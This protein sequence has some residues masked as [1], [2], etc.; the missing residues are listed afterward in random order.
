MVLVFAILVSY[1]NAFGVSSPYW[2]ERP[3]TM[4]IGETKTVDLNLQ[5]VVGDEA[6]TVNIELKDGEEVATLSE[7]TYTVAAGTSDTMV[8]LVITIP[9]D[10]VIGDTYTVSVDFKSVAEGEEGAIALG[11]GSTTTFDVIVSEKAKSGF[12]FNM[13]HG[14][15]LIAIILIIAAFYKYP[16]KKK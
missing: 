10:A 8:P 4:Y 1:A 3:L 13:Y 7:D 2:E 15:I 14:I 16:R 12:G 5:N 11:T 9:E 6:V